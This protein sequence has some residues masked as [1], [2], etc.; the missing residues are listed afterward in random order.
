MQVYSANAPLGDPISVVLVV[1]TGAVVVV[2]SGTWLVLVVGAGWV[3]VDDA[4]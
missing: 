4:G 2:V 3:V 1:G